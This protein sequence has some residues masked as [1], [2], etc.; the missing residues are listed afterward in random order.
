MLHVWIVLIAV[1]AI[2]IIIRWAVLWIGSRGHLKIAKIFNLKGDIVKTIRNVNSFF[3]WD[4]GVV[5]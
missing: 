3:S 4:P 2:S 5:E 1:V